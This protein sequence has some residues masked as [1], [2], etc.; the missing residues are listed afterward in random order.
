MGSTDETS[1]RLIR[2]DN[3]K[4]PKGIAVVPG[5]VGHWEYCAGG[6]GVLHKIKN[7]TT[8]G[9]IDNK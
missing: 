2:V 1:R 4:P 3:R 7:G 9:E 5:G 8:G 6:V